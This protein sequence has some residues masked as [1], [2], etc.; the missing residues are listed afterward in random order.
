MFDSEYVIVSDDA[1]AASFLFIMF[2]VVKKFFEINDSNMW[3]FN[4]VIVDTINLKVL[5]LFWFT[6]QIILQF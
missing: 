3:S 2:I 4:K 6:A 1:V 5:F